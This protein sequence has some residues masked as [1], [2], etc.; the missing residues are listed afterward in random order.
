MVDVVDEGNVPI[1]T[2]PWG[3]T[4]EEVAAFERAYEEEY[5]RRLAEGLAAI[6]PAHWQPHARVS[7]AS[8]QD[9]VVPL[10]DC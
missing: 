9:E 5:A 6:E 10:V 4:E 2:D 3:Y 8:G 7:S 1:P